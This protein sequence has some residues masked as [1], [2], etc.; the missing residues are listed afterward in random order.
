MFRVISG[1]ITVL[2]L[3]A[4]CGLHTAPAHAQPQ[5]CPLIKQISLEECRTLEKLFFDTDGP[6]WINIRGW[7]RSNQPC[8]WYGIT[9]LSEAWPRRI[10]KIDL[11]G[12]DL[13]GSLPGELSRLTQLRELR[14]DNSGPGHRFRKLTGNLPAV[15]GQ[16]EHLEVLLLG[17][18]EFTGSIPIEY[19]NLANLRELSLANSNLTGPIPESFTGL[20]NIRQMDLSGNQLAGSIPISLSALTSLEDLDLSGNLFTGPVPTA[21]GSLT[22]LQSL[23]LSSNSLTGVLPDTLANLSRLIW[24]SMANNDLAGALPLNTARF[25]AGITSCTLTGNQLCIPDNPVYEDL[26][27]EPVCGLPKDGSCKVCAGADC[28]ALETIFAATGGTAW[29][30]ATNWLAT[31]DLCSWHGVSCTGN[32]VTGLVLADNAVRGRLPG[33]LGELSFLEELNLSGNELSGRVPDSLSA[34]M[35]LSVVDL[36]DNQLSGPVPLAVASLGS[37]ARMCDLSGNLGLC[38]PDQPDY[39]AFGPT[40]CG[41][42]LTPLCGEFPL[43]SVSGVRAEPQDQAARVYWQTA[44]PAIGLRFD[45]EIVTLQDVLVA[46]SVKGVRQAPATYSYTVE[47]LQS[48]LHTFQIRQISPTGA[49]IVTDPVT[50]MLFEPGLTVNGPYPN[51]FSTRTQLTLVAGSELPVQVDVFDVSGRRIQTL[52]KGQP[53]LHVPWSLQFGQASLP[54]GTYFIRVLSQNTTLQSYQV[55]HIK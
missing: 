12:N 41:I 51:P 44:S 48:G 54:G 53:A 35:A 31:G 22:R 19:G 30:T 38:M 45:V 8:E 1:A 13:S 5:R 32:R 36:S 3:A 26:G 34:L 42:N 29:T 2:V 50:V 49:S 28:D 16:L 47:N 39:R 24:L 55:Q 15:L 23:N 4:A 7:L 25:A 33:L 18:N 14:I 9:C 40:I 20:Q 21:L 37:R 46:G 17:D 10:T 52:Y 6:N 11:S 43:V 27:S